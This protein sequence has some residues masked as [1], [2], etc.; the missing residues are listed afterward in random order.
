[1]SCKREKKNSNVRDCFFFFTVILKLD[2]EGSF[3]GNSSLSL[4]YG[5]LH[6]TEREI[7][8]SFE[9]SKRNRSFT[10]LV[11][12]HMCVLCCAVYSIWFG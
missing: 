12:T 6:K 3:G 7:N 11:N 8:N 10:A 4:I 2:L 1:M 9:R 5:V